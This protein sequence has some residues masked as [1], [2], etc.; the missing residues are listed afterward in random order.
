MPEAV[1]IDNPIICANINKIG[2]LM[3]GG[4]E[5]YERSAPLLSDCHVSVRLW[6]HTGRRGPAIYVQAIKNSGPRN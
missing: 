6:R 1:E 4:I 5:A 2:F 3:C